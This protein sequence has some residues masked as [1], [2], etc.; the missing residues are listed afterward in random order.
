VDRFLEFQV[1][2]VRLRQESDLNLFALYALMIRINLNS[3]NKFALK[4]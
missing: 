4:I 1:D 3:A 2:V